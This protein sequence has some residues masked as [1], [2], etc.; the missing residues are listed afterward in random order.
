MEKIKCNAPKTTQKYLFYGFLI[1]SVFVVSVILLE[2]DFTKFFQRFG[3]LPEVIQRMMV[4]DL[5]LIPEILKQILVSISL[6]YAALFFG[7][8]ISFFLAC[9]SAKNIAFNQTLS[10]IIKGIIATI[11]AIPSIVWVLM[12]VASIGFGNSGGMIGLIFPSV[13]YLTKS[14]A[15]SIEEDGN[16]RI[17]A[18]KA[19]GATRTSIIIHG[20]VP[21]VMPKFISWVAMRFENNIAEGISLGI[22][23]VGGVGYLLS[24]AIMKFD[25]PAISTII[26]MIFICMLSIE[27]II[28]QIK[29]KVHQE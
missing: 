1:V 29:K 15:A 26:L 24:K 23:G 16:E 17:E 14:F 3:N 18:L 12:V 2:M 21:Q 19:C 6:A 7:V 5:S 22:I 8:V 13:G 20:V 9:F 25:Y 4:L 28:Q 11:R 27:C 10:T